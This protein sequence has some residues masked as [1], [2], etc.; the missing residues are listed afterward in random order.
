M[1]KTIL[2]LLLLIAYAFSFGQNTKTI[3]QNFNW[4]ESP[5]IHNPY[6]L[7]F[8]MEI[9]SFEGAI[10]DDIHPTLPMASYRWEVPAQ[11]KLSV[12]IINIQYEPLDKKPTEDDAF[13]QS[14]LVFN[15]KINKNRNQHFAGLTFIPIIKNGAGQYQKVISIEINVNFK[16]SPSSTIL[17][18][19]N[20]FTSVLSE[21]DVY[22]IRVNQN[23]VYKLTYNFLKNDL[24]IENLDDIDP[25]KIQLLGNGGGMLPEPV[26]NF[27]HDDLEENAI[28]INGENDGSFDDNDYILFYGEESG[29]WI[30]DDPNDVFEYQKNIYT[31]FN[32]YFIKIGTN[33]GL[34]V[35]SRSSISNTEYTSTS[36]D[37]YQH[38]EEDQRNLLHEFG[39]A[40][41]SGKMW[42]G[43]I[44][45]LT[46][47][48]TYPNLF[49]FEN[50]E[51]DE[52]VVLSGSF[53]GRSSG[54]STFS[55]E[56]GNEQFNTSNITAVNLQNGESLYAK[57]VSIFES[58]QPQGNQF[59]VTLTFNASGENEGWVDFLTMNARRQL[60]MSS[61][62]S[63]MSFQDQRSTDFAT[64]T[65]NISNANN[66][67]IWDITNPQVPISQEN[68]NGSFGVE[69]ND[70]RH[71]LIFQTDG[72]LLTAEASGKVENQN[73]HG[74]DN[75]DMIIIYTND[76]LEVVER[77][78]DHRSSHS[79][80][81]VKLVRLDHI[82]NE[83]SSGKRD[84]TA[85]RDFA[86]MLHDRSPQFKYLLLFGDGS[87]DYKNIQELNTNTDSEISHNIIPPYETNQS[88]H[89][90][91]AFPSDD[92]YG[93]LSDGEGNSNLSGD[94]DISIG[95]MPIKNLEEANDVVDKIINYDTSPSTFGDWRNQLVFIG[96]DEDSSRH[97]KDADEVSELVADENPVF[98]QDKIYFDAFQQISTPG[99]QRFPD[100]TEAINQSI[101]KGVFCNL[102]FYRI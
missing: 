26:S 79:G 42:F 99:G 48:R 80:L 93:L 50:L 28:I 9:L 89:P 92:F 87:F 86:K 52:N 38:F 56:V 85:I 12:E 75:L 51:L 45:S 69:S 41:G 84:V 82:Y 16:S 33:N 30:H 40:Q 31:D 102:F 97:T 68:S 46:N 94:L 11:G 95:R 32:Y 54:N 65:F 67:I 22:K 71:F 23:G 3:N 4:D 43:D 1:K 15:K 36:F 66:A 20:T 49:N 17:R 21:G 62:S 72:N 98:N 64:T 77:L 83:F 73:L 2:S 18:G 96:D 53:A 8:P 35:T 19:P 7:S 13:I 14:D 44:F 63:Q 61:G 74:L 57:T 27:R 25:R 78:R 60:T 10:Y 58:F 59:D 47:E 91:T 88:L 29:Q 34:R 24:G 90:I 70:L 37:D 39:G 55:I 100:A 81:V 6:E 76:Y 5:I 101:F